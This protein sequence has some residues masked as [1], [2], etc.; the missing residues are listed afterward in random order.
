MIVFSL[1][2]EEKNFFRKDKTIKYN[3]YNQVASR[4][5]GHCFSAWNIVAESETLSN[6]EVY[7]IRLTLSHFTILCLALGNPISL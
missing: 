6:K 2:K 1:L 7:Q 3:R 5:I 4:K